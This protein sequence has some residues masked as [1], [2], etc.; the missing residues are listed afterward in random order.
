MPFYKAEHSNVKVLL[1]VLFFFKE[2]YFTRVY[3][4]CTR[5]CYKIVPVTNFNTCHHRNTGGAE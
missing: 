1:T 4:A 3:T 2:V 5:M